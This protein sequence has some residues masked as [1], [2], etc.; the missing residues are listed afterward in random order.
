MQQRIDLGLLRPRH[1]THALFR[2]ARNQARI[3]G[4]IGGELPPIIELP[5]QGAALD[6]D[7]AHMAGLHLIQKVGI[8]DLRGARAAGAARLKQVEQGHQQQRHDHP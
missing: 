3:F 4:R 8:G 5:R 2:Q 1:H 6:G 7:I